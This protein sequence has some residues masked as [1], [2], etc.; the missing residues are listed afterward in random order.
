MLRHLR[1]AHHFVKQ[2]KVILAPGLQPHG[3]LRSH[4]APMPIP[5]TAH[6][7]PRCSASGTQ[8]RRSI[9]NAGARAQRSAGRLA[10][11]RRSIAALGAPGVFRLVP[12]L[13]SKKPTQAT[14]SQVVADSVVVPLRE[15]KGRLTE[16]ASRDM[17]GIGLP[18]LTG[19]RRR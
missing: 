19:R 11:D 1:I 13:V 4:V 5:H 6:L 18:R 7:T 14:W 9:P 3:R 17:E 8:Q 2:R 15:G 12:S 10:R 16:E